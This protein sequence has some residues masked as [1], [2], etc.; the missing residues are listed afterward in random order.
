MRGADRREMERF[1]RAVGLGKVYP[2]GEGV[3]GWKLD[4]LSEL[5]LF[6]DRLRPLL[7]P[8]KA[9]EYDATLDKYLA[10]GVVKEYLGHPPK[11]SRQRFLEREHGRDRPKQ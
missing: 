10:E 5:K 2:L 7:P 6:L 1:R 4:L 8:A 11:G 3:W 9:A